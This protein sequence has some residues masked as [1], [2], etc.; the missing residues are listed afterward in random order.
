M[1][2]FKFDN[3]NSINSVWVDLKCKCFAL[4]HI[5]VNSESLGFYSQHWVWLA[6]FRAEP[7]LDLFIKQLVLVIVNKPSKPRRSIELP[8]RKLLICF[9]PSHPEI[10]ILQQSLVD[11][12]IECWQCLLLTLSVR[13]LYCIPALSSLLRLGLTVP[14]PVAPPPPEHRLVIGHHFRSRDLAAKLSL[15][16]AGSFIMMVWN[17]HNFTC[18]GRHQVEASK[19]QTKKI[20]THIIWNGP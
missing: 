9:P 6:C 16:S 5:D 11:W 10:T 15:V 19:W 3:V 20:L 1:S 18:L 2:K 13:P 4:T 12:I 17:W 14:D 8:P 7:K